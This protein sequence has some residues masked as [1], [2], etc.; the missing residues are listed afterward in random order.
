MG[1]SSSAEL[2]FANVVLTAIPEYTPYTIHDVSY[3]YVYLDT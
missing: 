2:V 3:A 1:R